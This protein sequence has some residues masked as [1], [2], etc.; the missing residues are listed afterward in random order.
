MKKLLLLFGGLM[1]V[2]L[3]SLTA[4]QSSPPILDNSSSFQV[5]DAIKLGLSDDGLILKP[6]KALSGDDKLNGT[7][8]NF[9]EFCSKG[10]YYDKVT[11]ACK[12]NDVC[13]PNNPCSGTT[14]VCEPA[15]D[16]INYTCLCNDSSCGAGKTCVGGQCINCQKGVNCNCPSG[17]VSNGE[18]RCHTPND[19]CSSKPC[20]GETPSCSALDETQYSCSCT[21][22]SC[23]A[24]KKCEDMT[25]QTCSAGEDCGCKASGKE[26][27]GNGG[28]R[29]PGDKISDGNGGCRCPDCY[30]ADGTWG[31]CKKTCECVSCAKAKKCIDGECVNC[32]LGE[33]CGCFDD[34]AY[35]DGNGIC[36]LNCEHTPQSCANENGGFVDDWYIRETN[37]G[38][39]CA[40]DR[41]IL[42]LTNETTTQYDPVSKKNVKLYRTKAWKPFTTAWFGYLRPI[43]VTKG[44]KGGYV[45][46]YDN[47]KGGISWVGEDARVWGNATVSGVVTDKAQ[48]YGDA[49]ING[50]VHDN[51]KVY[52]KVVVGAGG[53][54]YGNAV[55]Y[56]NTN[57]TIGRSYT[58]GEHA[59]QGTYWTCSAYGTEYMCE[60]MQKNGP[61][62]QYWNDAYYQ[63]C[64]QCKCVQCNQQQ[65]GSD[66]AVCQDVKFYSTGAYTFTGTACV[67]R[68]VCLKENTNK[69]FQIDTK[70]ENSDYPDSGT[71][72]S[73]RNTLKGIA[74]YLN[75]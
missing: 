32:P 11:K 27:D 4:G 23:P 33:D 37:D 2:P 51:A 49:T 13:N 45:A 61:G 30:A 70:W 56:S 53:A 55:A 22:T 67:N 17:Q 57:L 29:C 73:M 50:N 6:K 19:P 42:L 64:S 12:L 8:G 59:G 44:M 68:R 69:G 71:C 10:Y 25:C 24:G 62:S 48:V 39:E 54:V 14:P 72:D 43:E 63:N 66:T 5:A 35:S 28:C 36:Q 75:Y 31:G 3:V 26:A 21:S 20:S 15:G 47:I 40:S 18:G 9:E 58:A 52:G 65:A 74:S 34:N 41:R 7:D 46:S 38:C 60:D 1:L 16:G